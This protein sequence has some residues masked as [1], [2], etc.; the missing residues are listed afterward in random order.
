MK[1]YSSI[2]GNYDS[3]RDDIEVFN[4]SEQDLFKNPVMNS[5]RYKVLSHKF[6]DEDTCWVDGNIIPL[7]KDKISELLGD[8]DV[9]VFGHPYRKNIYL[10][11]VACQDRLP[12]VMQ[13]KLLEQIMAYKQ[14]GFNGEQLAECG[15]ILRKNNE[16]VKRFNDMW[17]S[18]ICRWQWRDQI[19]FPY[20]VWKSGVKVKY[21]EGNVRNHNLF[22][23]EQCNHL[24]R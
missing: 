21:L 8:Y 2:C 18:E 19:S 11:A 22:K 9:V 17:W 12:V 10:E 16:A 23:Y 14:E 20:C 3:L 6:F 4:D 1:F 24:P 5:K 13:P 15:V 7:D